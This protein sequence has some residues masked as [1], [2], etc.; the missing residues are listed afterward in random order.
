[1]ANRVDQGSVI[2]FLYCPELRN[3][4]LGHSDFQV[5]WLN[6]SLNLNANFKWLPRAFSYGIYDVF[7]AFKMSQNDKI[8]L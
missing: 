6:F 1:M 4:S 7:V 5:F 8:W 2:F 3:E